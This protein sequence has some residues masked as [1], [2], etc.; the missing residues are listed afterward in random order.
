MDR[1]K[2][3]RVPLLT[4]AYEF[5]LHCPLCGVQLQEGC[6]DYLWSY[7]SRVCDRCGDR[8]RTD[9]QFYWCGMDVLGAFDEP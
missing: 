5:E 8:A 4:N 6:T 2:P 1:E 7:H 9:E 3:T